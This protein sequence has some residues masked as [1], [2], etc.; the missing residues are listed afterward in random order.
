MIINAPF[1]Q[2]GIWLKK[3]YIGGS[4]VG[5]SKCRECKHFK[6]YT[7]KAKSID[8]VCNFAEALGEAERLI[9]AGTQMLVDV[10][11]EGE[12]EN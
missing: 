1:H 7:E 12:H 2:T 3:C 5:D 10:F 6:G 11:G 4:F 9:Q 8:V